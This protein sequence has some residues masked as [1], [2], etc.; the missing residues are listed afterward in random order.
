MVVKNLL[1]VYHKYLFAQY[2]PNFKV[3]IT[4]GTQ[5]E[6]AINNGTIKNDDPLRFKKN[7]GSN[8]KAV[9]VSNIN[10][11]DPYQLIAPIAPVQVL[12]G[13]LPRPRREF[14]ELYMPMSQVFEK[15]K[16][17]WLLKPLDPRPITNP[18]PSRF[19]VNKRYAYHQG[20][21]HD[22][23]RC[24]SLCHA[25][26]DLIDNKVIAPPTR[27]SI[28]NN[29][30]PNHNFG[31]RMRINCLMTEEESKE[32]PS[33]LI[34]D[35]PECFMMT[36]EELMGMTSTIGYDIWSEDALET[37]NYP[38]S[39]NGGR[40]F[41]LQS[42]YPISTNGE[43]HFEPQSSNSTSTNR[44]RHFKTPHLE[45]N[46]LIETLNKSTQQTLAEEDEFLKQL[47]KTQA[48]ISLWGLLTA[49]YKHRQ[50][51]VDL[52]NQI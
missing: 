35:L 38:T 2:F 10:K 33:E 47:Q 40:H 20:P 19:V 32:D 4:T 5:I 45:T 41:K 15:L 6:D 44:G 39:T 28:T 27:P 29:P 3:L 36:W 8:S 21:G 14:H 1:P 34:Y 9:K 18:L 23:D 30:L 11:N 37:K 48:N 16:A 43:R 7:L 24:F 49:S 42:N 25:I 13:P 12:Q 51:L 46:N 17:K 50:N 31:R 52:L 26:Q 22:T